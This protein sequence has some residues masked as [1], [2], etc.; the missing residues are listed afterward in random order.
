MGAIGPIR[1]CVLIKCCVNIFRDKSQQALNPP[2][3][4][5]C[6]YHSLSLSPRLSREQLLKVV[7]SCLYTMLM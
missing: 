3:A 4:A 1:G 2:R 6:Y 7:Y 5:L